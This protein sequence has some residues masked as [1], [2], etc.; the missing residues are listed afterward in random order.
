M[1][2]LAAKIMPIVKLIVRPMLKKTTQH[3][4][5]YNFKWKSVE[6]RRYLGWASF[7]LQGQKQEKQEEKKR[8]LMSV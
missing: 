7:Q 4:S 5:N 2:R 6:M 8:E 3:L 1:P